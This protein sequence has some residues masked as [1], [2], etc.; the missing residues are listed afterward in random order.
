MSDFEEAGLALDGFR[1]V[2]K[3]SC[4]V[5]F[6]RGVRPNAFKTKNQGRPVFDECI[7]I[8]KQPADQMLRI[9]RYMEEDDKELYPQEWAQ[10]ERTGETRFMGTP[11]EHWAQLSETQKAE[12]QA[13][14]VH[15]VEQFAQLPDSFG[16][17]IMGF[18]EL[19]SRAQVFIKQGHDSELIGKIRAESDEKVAAL[20]MQLD[21]MKAM[22][23]QMQN[24]QPEP[25]VVAAG[26]LPK[27]GPGRPPLN[28]TA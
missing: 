3:S 18:N 7:L 12:F 27:R 16:Q 13:M 1:P 6:K 26:E 5:M 11:I 22:M 28:R 14:K 8:I 23:E 2:A 20:Q 9:E 15:T 17:S 10:F 4:A 19:R 21:Q 25:E 24:P